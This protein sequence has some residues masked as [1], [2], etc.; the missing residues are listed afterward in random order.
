[1]YIYALFSGQNKSIICA[2]HSDV[3]AAKTKLPHGYKKATI[4]NLVM[5]THKSFNKFVMAFDELSM[6]EHCCIQ[7]LLIH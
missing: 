3:H 6:Q 2:N 7:L 4:A 5:N 1:M